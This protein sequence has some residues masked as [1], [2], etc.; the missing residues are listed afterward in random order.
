[1]IRNCISLLA[2]FALSLGMMTAQAREATPMAENPAIEKR[3]L[4]ITTELRCLVCQNQS[5]ADSHA[6]L[7]NDFRREIRLLIAEGKSDQQILDYMVERYGDFVRY[8]PP[9]KGT[10]ILLWLGPAALLILGLT[11]LVRFLRRRN[12]MLGD[13]ALSAEEQKA[14][15]ALL[16]TAPQDKTPQ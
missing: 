8:K 11:L 14:A 10:T 13:T 3:V 1:M 6:D 5:I 15:E 4:A 16:D 9:L 2:A 12:Q 7:A